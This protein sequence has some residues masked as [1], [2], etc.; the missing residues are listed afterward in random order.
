MTVLCAYTSVKENNIPKY[1][2]T[3]FNELYNQ[4]QTLGINYMLKFGPTHN[5]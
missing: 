5:Y 4:Q 1:T 2:F 3:A